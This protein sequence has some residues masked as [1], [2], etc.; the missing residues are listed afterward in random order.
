MRT[1]SNKSDRA[2]FTAIEVLIALAVLGAAIMS[3]VVSLGSASS[4]RIQDRSLVHAANVLDD[5]LEHYRGMNATEVVA[6]I[7][8]GPSGS[9]VAAGHQVIYTGVGTDNAGNELLKNATL[10]VQLLNE[11]TTKQL[12]GLGT[13]VDLDGNGDENN[14]VYTNYRGVAP[15]RLT[16]TWEASPGQNRSRTVWTMFYERGW[17]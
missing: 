1:P 17:V 12:Y 3:V 2:A 6:E 13:A 10:T 14:S 7:L 16:L 9:A 5:R 15:V 4:L 8:A 11:V